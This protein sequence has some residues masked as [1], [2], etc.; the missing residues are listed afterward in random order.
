MRTEILLNFPPA[1]RARCSE[2]LDNSELFPPTMTGDRRQEVSFVTNRRMPTRTCTRTCIPVRAP[3]T[4]ACICL[5][6]AFCVTPTPHS[7][8][9]ICTCTEEPQHQGSL[10]R[11]FSNASTWAFVTHTVSLSDAHSVTLRGS[12]TQPRT[13]ACV[14]A[15]HTLQIVFIGIDLKRSLLEDELDACLLTAAELKQHQVPPHTCATTCMHAHTN[16]RPR[17]H[18]RACTYTN[19]RSLTHTRTRANV[20]LGPSGGRYS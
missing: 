7:L 15:K 10:V 2:L 3:C 17:I 18:A 5:L 13:H 1:E 6:K 11:K 9:R 4:R 20:G 14:R 16:M 19:T 12:D 8:S